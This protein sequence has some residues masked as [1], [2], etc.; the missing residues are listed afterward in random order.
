MAGCVPGLS[1]TEG[2][3]VNSSDLSQSVTCLLRGRRQ[4][5]GEGCCLPFTALTMDYRAWHCITGYW[6]S[7]IEPC[8]RTHEAHF[9]KLVKISIVMVS[10]LLLSPMIILVVFMLKCVS[11]N[12]LR[13]IAAYYRCLLSEMFSA[14]WHKTQF[15]CLAPGQWLQFTRRA[16]RVRCYP[17][18]NVTLWPGNPLLAITLDTRVMD[19]WWASDTV[20]M[21]LRLTSDMDCT[22]AVAMGIMMKCLLSSNYIYK[23]LI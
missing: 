2:W 23:T 3:P 14:R 5:G 10:L 20:T 16:V 8:N 1:E 13:Q 18:H 15:M 11:T 6:T 19:L 17:G 7:D 9:Y 22:L 21:N 12:W 4:W